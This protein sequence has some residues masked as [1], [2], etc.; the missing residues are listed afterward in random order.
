MATGSGTTILGRQVIAS[1]P[2]TEP[3]LFFRFTGTLPGASQR[4]GVLFICLNRSG[5]RFVWQPFP[6]YRDGRAIVNIPPSPSTAYTMVA[7]WEIPGIGFAWETI[8]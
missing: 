4:I 3:R 6:M 1:P 8:A 7:E 5:N 2:S